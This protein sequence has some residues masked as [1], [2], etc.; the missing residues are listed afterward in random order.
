[1][2]SEEKAENRKYIDPIYGQSA[3]EVTEQAT[4]GVRSVKPF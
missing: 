2:E 4:K 1:M 3:V